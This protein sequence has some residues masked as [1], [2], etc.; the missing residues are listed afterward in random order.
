MYTVDNATSG[1]LAYREFAL[2]FYNGGILA[3]GDT[4]FAVYVD[5]GAGDSKTSIAGGNTNANSTDAA[6]ATRIAILDSEKTN[7]LFY[8]QA[9]T[10]A[11]GTYQYIKKETG[12]A[13]ADGAYGVAG[14]KLD[15][16]SNITHNNTGTTLAT[17]TDG[18]GTQQQSQ[19]LVDSIAAGA[20]TRVWI[21]IWLEG[22]C[23]TCKN[24]AANGVVKS[25]LNFTAI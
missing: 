23:A 13:Q 8:Y 15:A 17:I 20:N 19:K 21:R 1:K 22:T 18:S 5:V 9:S 7:V 10:E 6:N 2:D 4:A 14:Y 3:N 25:Y 24:S 16:C 11:N 12:V